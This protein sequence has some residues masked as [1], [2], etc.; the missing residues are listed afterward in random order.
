MLSTTDYIEGAAA[1][2]LAYWGLAKESGWKK[3]AL[4]GIAAYLA[5]GVYSDATS[6]SATTTTSGG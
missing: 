3:W 2:G 5:Y 1:I 4:I 6:A